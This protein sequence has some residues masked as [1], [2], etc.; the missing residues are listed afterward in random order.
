MAKSSSD[1]PPLKQLSRDGPV[2]DPAMWIVPD[3]D[4][5]NSNSS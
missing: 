1:H 3:R 5:G 4:E 2:L